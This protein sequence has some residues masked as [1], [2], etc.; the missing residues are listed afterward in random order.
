MLTD[1][2]N[3]QPLNLDDVM[4]GK[5]HTCGTEVEVL[6]KDSVPPRSNKP[7]S[8]DWWSDLYYTECP[9][10]RF[11]SISEP[12]SGPKVFLMKKFKQ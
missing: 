1:I 10:C 8:S 3:S 11:E 7:I 6:R 12:P 2:P 4:V 9:F 5:C